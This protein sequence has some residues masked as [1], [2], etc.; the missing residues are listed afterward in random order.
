MMKPRGKKK[1]LETFGQEE[2]A[3]VKSLLTPE[4]WCVKWMATTVL[5][6]Q[7][8]QIGQNTN[9]WIVSAQDQPYILFITIQSIWWKE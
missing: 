9:K 1:E 2:T 4:W 8:D 3:M 6:A 7:V 5:K